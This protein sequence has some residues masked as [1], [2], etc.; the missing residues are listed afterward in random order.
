[1]LIDIAG[2]FDCPHVLDLARQSLYN[3]VSA[4]ELLKIAYERED[5]EVL[6]RQALPRLLDYANTGRN[7]TIRQA[8]GYSLAGSVKELLP[9]HYREEIL[10]ISIVQGVSTNGM[11]YLWGW[12][13]KHGEIDRFIHAIKKARPAPALVDVEGKAAESGI[14]GVTPEI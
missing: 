4:I 12:M 8:E 10:R 13:K 11:E 2:Y 3:S 1:M 7:R 6:I 9:A 14:G 5:D